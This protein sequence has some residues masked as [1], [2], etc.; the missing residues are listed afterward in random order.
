MAASSNPP[1]PTRVRL[2]PEEVTAFLN[3]NPRWRF[4]DGSITRSFKFSTYMD[5]IA[6]VNRVAELAEAANHH[7]DLVVTW[8]KV[9]LSLTTHDAGGVTPLDIEMAGRVDELPGP[10]R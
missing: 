8:R 5:G 3:A 2:L 4:A 7:P 1:N 6:F 9:V 10:S